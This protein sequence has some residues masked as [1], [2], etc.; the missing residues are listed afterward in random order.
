MMKQVKNI[1][2][3]VL[4]LAMLT[5]LCACGGTVEE[6]AE[7]VLGTYTGFGL[8]LDQ[9]YVLEDTLSTYTVTLDE[10]GT[11]YLDWGEDN[12]GPISSWSL[13]E[14]EIV[15]EAGVSTIQ[16]T[17]SDGIMVLDLEDG[18]VMCFARSEDDMAKL[19]VITMEDYLAAK[20]EA[21]PSQEAAGEETA[22]IPGDYYVFAMEQDGYCIASPDFPTDTDGM[23]TM[24]EDGTGVMLTGDVENRF[25][26]SAEGTELTWMDE[27]GTTPVPY[28][29]TIIEDGVFVMESPE[30]G[31]KVYY[32][33]TNADTSGISTITVEEY[34][35]AQGQD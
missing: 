9:R 25:T 20:G 6:T 19:D 34:K 23:V 14:D 5:A 8:Y 31:G 16:G 7:A 17:V 28:A 21:D 13:T 29:V 10:G 33:K 3:G 2:T 30:D 15:I 24:K 22:G 12:Q 11:G 35:Q 1:L 4:A 26:W 27:T 32:A 18:I